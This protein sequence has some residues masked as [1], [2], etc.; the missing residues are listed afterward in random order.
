MIGEKYTALRINLEK[1]DPSIVSTV[2]T[3][4]QVEEVLGFKLPLTARKRQQWWGNENSAKRSQCAAW[5]EAGFLARVN[6]TAEA[7]TFEREG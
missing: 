3:F 6:L 4:A 5:M 7:V 2:M 1:L